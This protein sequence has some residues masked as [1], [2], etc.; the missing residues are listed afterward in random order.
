M[1]HKSTKS[2]LVKIFEDIVDITLGK[3]DKNQAFE[4]TKTNPKTTGI[5][6]DVIDG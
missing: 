1:E 5:A 6:G 3:A 4:R 2:E